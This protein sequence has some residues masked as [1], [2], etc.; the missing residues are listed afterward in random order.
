MQNTKLSFTISL[1]LITVH[2]LTIYYCVD[3]TFLITNWIFANLTC[4]EPS[5]LISFCVYFYTNV[6]FP[7]QMNV[8][9]T[10]DINEPSFHLYDCSSSMWHELLTTQKRWFI[11]ISGIM[12]IHLKGKKRLLEMHVYSSIQKI[13]AEGSLYKSIQLVTLIGWGQMLTASSG[14]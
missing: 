1:Y 3:Y 9:N 7:L 13:R 5:A 4:R 6:F 2:F 14:D 8:P 10:R 12:Y 11:Y